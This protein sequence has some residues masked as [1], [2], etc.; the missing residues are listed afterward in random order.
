MN[1]YPR[2]S[3]IRSV[4]SPRC[5]FASSPSPKVSPAS[6]SRTLSEPRTARTCRTAV[7]RRAKPPTMPSRSYCCTRRPGSPVCADA[8]PGATRNSLRCP[9]MSLVCR[10]VNVP[11]ALPPRGRSSVI[12][13]VHPCPATSSMASMSTARDGREHVR[14]NPR[15]TAVVW[16]ISAGG[17][18]AGNHR[19]M[20]R[21]WHS[22]ARPRR[23]RFPRR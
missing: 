1:W 8:F 10:I 21:R 20:C 3:I 4:G 7:A 14:R 13:C 9:C 12:G 2:A 16:R 11:V 17:A 15:V 5:K 23:R 22:Q 18:D 19:A 6:T